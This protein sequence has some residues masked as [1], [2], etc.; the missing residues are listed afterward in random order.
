[1]GSNLH[2]R[3]CVTADVNRPKPILLLSIYG[4]L[5]CWQSSTRFTRMTNFS[6]EIRNTGKVQKLASR[7]KPFVTG[8]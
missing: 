2:H 3:H 6:V 4:T 7:V 5:R 8:G 1:M